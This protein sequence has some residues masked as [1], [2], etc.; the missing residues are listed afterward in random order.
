MHDLQ[1]IDAQSMD[2]SPFLVRTSLPA[3]SSEIKLAKNKSKFA[4]DKPLLEEAKSETS[5]G[6]SD[7]EHVD[8][9]NNKDYRTSMLR[10][11]EE[12]DLHLVDSSK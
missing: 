7:I 3:D 8:P 9:V 11:E 2:I 6:L 10:I 4:K 5:V 12:G 1:E